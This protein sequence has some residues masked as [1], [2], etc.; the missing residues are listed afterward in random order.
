MIVL[1]TLVEHQLVRKLNRKL[2]V[3]KLLSIL[4]AGTIDQL[5][6]QA[7]RCPS[8]EVNACWSFGAV[9]LILGSL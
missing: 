3:S 9:M 4:E 1:G 8:C 2:H 6:V 7:V 5:K